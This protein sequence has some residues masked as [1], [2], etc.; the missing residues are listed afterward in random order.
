MAFKPLTQS[1]IDRWQILEALAGV[2]SLMDWIPLMSTNF[3]SPRHLISLAELL[4]R[5][6]FQPV[7]CT[8][9]VPPRH[10]KT[11]TLLHYVPWRLHRDPTTEI[12]YC[13]YEA[14]LAYTKS[15]KM[16][17]LA[18]AT[19]VQFNKSQRSVKQ[20]ETI[21]GG[22]LIATGVG[23][24]ITGKGAKLLLIDDPLK[25]REEAESP[26]IRQRFGTGLLLQRSLA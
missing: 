20:W 22:K 5:S 12:A 19:G 13:T 1:E 7:Y 14:N 23:G 25:N 16:R 10:S 15:R 9:S 26:V 2:E 17:E 4:V 18:E 21:Q 24:P 3:E 8:L 11:E 6:Q